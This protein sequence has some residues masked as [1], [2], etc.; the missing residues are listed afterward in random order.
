MKTTWQL[1]V[2]NLGGICVGVLFALYTHFTW[3]AAPL[4]AIAEKAARQG[5]VRVIVGIRPTE[6][7]KPDTELE[8]IEHGRA[9][10][11]QER[12]RAV[13]ERV[14]QSIPQGASRSTT[15]IFHVPAIAVDVNPAELATLRSHPDV[16]YVIESESLGLHLMDSA[17][18]VGAPYAWISGYT[19]QG[20]TVAIVDTGVLASH[21]FLAG[22]VVDEACYSTTTS[23]YQGLCTNGQSSMAGA[24]A[25]SPC[26]VSIECSHGTHV[27]G[28]ATGRNG[29][30]G[31]I[32]FNGVAKDASIVAIKA[33]SQSLS[34]SSIRFQW[35]D[36]ISAFEHVHDVHVAGRNVVAVNMSVGAGVYSGNCDSVLPA[37]KTAIDN[38][39]A[40]GIATVISTGNDSSGAGIAFP[41]CVTG[42][43]SVGASTKA[44]Q[45]AG[46]SN[47][48]PA[49]T[50][51]APGDGFGPITGILSSVPTSDQYEYWYGTS[52]AAPHVAGA[53]AVLRQANPTAPMANI[54]AALTTGPLIYDSRNGLYKPR[55]VVDPTP[56]MMSRLGNISS[57][58]LVLTGNNVMIAGF[59]V[60]GYGYKHVA[61]TATG[62]SLA[63][64]GIPNYLPNPRLTVV[65]M[66]DNQVIGTNDDWQTDP[67]AWYLQQVGYAPSDPKEA[68]LIMDLPP[69]LYSAIVDGGSS[70]GTGVSVVGVF[71]VDTPQA[72]LLNI[73]TR[74]EVQGAGDELIAGFQI[75]GS[76][77]MTVVIRATGPS[78]APF[79]IS[80]PLPDPTLTLH[81]SSDNAVIGSNDNWQNDPNSAN[82][83]AKYRP[84]DPAEAALL[85]TLPPGNYTVVVQD[86]LGRPGVSVVSVD[87]PH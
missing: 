40:D 13:Q 62:P 8:R 81:R 70:G 32:T 19:G 60:G 73:S 85:V 67:Y 38:L 18:L 83:P 2:R 48:S 14:L 5:T 37:L 39:T 49:T 77:P 23:G 75:L 87:V 42:V 46:F 64:F 58:S 51:L 56:V 50:I 12:V 53:I 1:A 29:V 10:V 7:W 15:R 11:Q 78:L 59:Q 44:D 34:D 24:G 68:G 25:A 4:D 74:A 45:L 28:I 86:S 31:G 17:P 79:G 30:S 80:N 65:R 55:L 43:V 47:N 27:A 33:G 84:S 54:M 26:T 22:K 82:I 21:P 41:S 35:A 72:P 16:E 52:M 76:V 61:I 6:P 3:A 36:V 66:A 63:P 69:G 57:R 71:D 20:T 9:A